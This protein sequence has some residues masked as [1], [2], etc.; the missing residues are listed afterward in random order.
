MREVDMETRNHIYKF[1]VDNKE[2]GKYIKTLRKEKGWTAEELAEK[3]YCSPKT[4]SSWETGVR[5]PSLDMLVS[6]SELLGVSVHSLLLPYDNCSCDYIGSFDDFS[7]GLAPEE[8]NISEEGTDEG[9]ARLYER[10]E[11]LL[12]RMVAGV[13][14]QKDRNELKIISECID[15]GLGPVDPKDLETK[16][17]KSY[18]DAIVKWTALRIENTAKIFD[19]FDADLPEYRRYTLFKLGSVFRRLY[20]SEDLNKTLKS[21]NIIEKS[22]LLTTCILCEKIRCSKFAEDIYNAG[23]L[24]IK[25]SFE[26]IPDEIQDI[27]NKELDYSN[28][29]RGQQDFYTEKKKGNGEEGSFWMLNED[30]RNYD[31]ILNYVTYLFY[32]QKDY[33]IDDILQESSGADYREY[34]KNLKMEGK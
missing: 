28:E 22:I 18:E 15:T 2:T 29:P 20:A 30:M 6:L 16:Q 7:R 8:Y 3:L 34:L 23:G 10:E 1:D 21:I 33:K 26:N 9:G 19:I 27:L 4:V 12:Q 25:K 31:S 13:F 32:R 11:Y 5:M 17:I 14:N 24:F